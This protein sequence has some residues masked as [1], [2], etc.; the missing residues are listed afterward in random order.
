MDAIE[1]RDI[2]S[3]LSVAARAVWDSSELDDASLPVISE[4]SAL[5]LIAPEIAWSK[6]AIEMDGI[7]LP[8]N[9][10]A[11]AAALY[12]ADEIEDGLLTLASWAADEVLAS[13]DVDPVAAA[14]IITGAAQQMRAIFDDCI[15]RIGALPSPQSEAA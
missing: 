9:A 13:Y 1:V 2:L 7:D 12:G 10:S 5:G 6:L 8:E 15:A 4:L 3:K 14:E 11:L